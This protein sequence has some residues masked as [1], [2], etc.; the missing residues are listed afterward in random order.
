MPV[1]TKNTLSA[2]EFCE[3]LFEGAMTTKEILQRINQKFP[4][5]DLLRTE[6]NSRISALKRSALVDIEYRDND[7]KWRLNSVDERYYQRSENAKKGDEIIVGKSP[8]DRKLP[9][10]DP[11]EREMCELVKLFDECILSVRNKTAATN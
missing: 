9:P 1:E 6:V 2:R 7:R 11:K 8:K 3:V 5:I 4:N 10:L